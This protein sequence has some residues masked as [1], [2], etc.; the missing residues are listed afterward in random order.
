MQC[1]TLTSFKSQHYHLLDEGSPA[2]DHLDSVVVVVRLEV[3]E[4]LLLHGSHI[5][6]LVECGLLGVGDHGG[7][8][9]QSARNNIIITLCIDL[10]VH[11]WH[12]IALV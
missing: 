12:C 6:D 3:G 8:Q 7:R 2:V 11:R 9:L 10:S 1:L 4:L 5:R